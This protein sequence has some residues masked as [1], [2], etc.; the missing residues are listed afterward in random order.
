MG[1]IKWLFCKKLYLGGLLISKRP[2]NRE[3]Y[4][5]YIYRWVLRVVLVTYLLEYSYILLFLLY[6]P[7]FVLQPAYG[8]HDHLS[9]L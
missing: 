1:G 5:R 4:N 3:T 6:R 9:S 2:I 7:A 8:L